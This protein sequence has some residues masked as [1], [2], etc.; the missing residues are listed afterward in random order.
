MRYTNK[1]TLFE[2]VVRRHIATLLV[3]A[4]ATPALPLECRLRHV[5]QGILEH[6]LQA[7]TIAMMRLMIAASNRNPL[8]ADEVNRIGWEGGLI[9][10]R[11]AILAGP[12][13]PTDPD[14][15]ARQFID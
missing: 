11:S 1:E 8:L 9:R 12:D 13:Q 14:A 10:E 15:L 7:D 6:A 2:A 5:G 3:P 4:E